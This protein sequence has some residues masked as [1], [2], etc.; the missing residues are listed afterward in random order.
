MPREFADKTTHY[1]VAQIIQRTKDLR[2]EPLTKER[3]PYV[4]KHG[5]PKER[6]IDLVTR[7]ED[8]A[9]AGATCVVRFCLY[10]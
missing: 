4:I 6:L 9:E 3:V 5:A 2:A 10:G 1:C 7:P 8:L